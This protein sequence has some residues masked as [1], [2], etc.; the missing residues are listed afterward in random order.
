[1]HVLRSV[2]SSWF[3]LGF[4]GVVSFFW[5]AYRGE[6]DACDSDSDRCSGEDDAC[7][8]G[9]S[10]GMMLVCEACAFWLLQSESESESESPKK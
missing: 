3:L 7:E 10:C 6:G 5:F 4:V 1:M 9:V 2:C 8:V